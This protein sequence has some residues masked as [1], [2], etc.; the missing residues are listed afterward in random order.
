M[1]LT[2]LRSHNAQLLAENGRFKQVEAD[3]LRFEES[4]RIAWNKIEELE[5]VNAQIAAANKKLT[6]DNAALLQRVSS[7]ESRVTLLE[8]SPLVLELCQ[9]L[10]DFEERLVPQLDEECL[11]LWQVNYSEA[12]LGVWKAKFGGARKDLYALGAMLT[13]IR[14]QR[15]PIAHPSVDRSHALQWKTYLATDVAHSR[16]DRTVSAKLIDIALSH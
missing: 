6:E 10:L 2:A 7:L 15:N 5:R 4:S 8:P 1:V 12:V 3:R 16:I 13:V 11:F 14:T 9:F